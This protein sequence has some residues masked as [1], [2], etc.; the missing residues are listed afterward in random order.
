MPQEHAT[1]PTDH[2]LGGES[3]QDRTTSS[4]N[5]VGHRVQTIVMM[6]GGRWHVL[7][8][9]IWSETFFNVFGGDC[10]PNNVGTAYGVP[11]QG[12]QL[13]LLFVNQVTGWN[14]GV[15]IC[16]DKG[17]WLVTI[18]NA[19]EKELVRSKASG[20]NPSQFFIGLNDVNKGSG[21][22]K[23][24]WVED[25]DYVPTYFNWATGE[26]NNYGGSG[27]WGV[28]MMH[29]NGAWADVG[30]NGDSS[31]NWHGRVMCQFEHQTPSS[32]PSGQPTSAPSSPTAVPTNY[33]SVPT[34]QPTS[35]PSNQPSSLPTSQP[36]NYNKKTCQES[37]DCT[38]PHSTCHLGQCLCLRGYY[39][40][41]TSGG[42]CE[43][44][45]AGYI[46]TRTVPFN[47]PVG[48]GCCARLFVS[49]DFQRIATINHA[50]TPANIYLSLDA[51][52]SWV[53]KQIM[54]VG[55]RAIVASDSFDK[56]LIGC[57]G[58]GGGAT[59]GRLYMST[60]QGSSWVDYGDPPNMNFD[61]WSFGT[62][63]ANMSTIYGSVKD[64][65]I[66]ISTDDG[67]TWEDFVD[68]ALYVAG[69]YV[70]DDRALALVSTWQSK[71][72][73]YNKSADPQWRA[74]S[75]SPL[76]QGGVPVADSSFR[77]FIVGGDVY[78]PLYV[79]EDQGVT[80]TG[81][82]P[83]GHWVDFVASPDF[84][85]IIGATWTSSQHKANWPVEGYEGTLWLS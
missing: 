47:P 70:S 73:F 53:T 13:C 37:I 81:Y 36:S 27:E 46:P 35:Q 65:Y 44:V 62:F 33:P 83:N 42:H 74:L 8:L 25:P 85:V 48:E 71:Y 12:Y 79:S 17:G 55:A 7:I 58:T 4:K 1:M 49:K 80:W 32:S 39:F 67:R 69:S 43:T 11:N 41:N 31:R 68:A 82:G 75:S 54:C 78:T 15:N 28:W 56:I 63:D 66:K 59:V 60:D 30:V 64:K 9:V 50:W 84:S 21:G 6:V 14:N 19:D 10:G 76:S 26:P 38:L 18:K 45:P 16:K 34:S 29:G 24:R 61:W 57:A 3:G 5:K 20:T 2:D 72:S 40:R 22:R 51:G 23:W 52:Y 77:T